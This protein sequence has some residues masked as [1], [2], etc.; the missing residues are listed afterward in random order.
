MGSVKGLWRMDAA[1]T[2]PFP[3]F[4][5]DLVTFEGFCPLIVVRVA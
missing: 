1:P 3:S 2:T 4:V 5:E